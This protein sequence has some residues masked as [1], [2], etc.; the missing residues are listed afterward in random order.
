MGPA[1]FLRFGRERSGRPLL[2]TVRPLLVTVITIYQASIMCQAPCCAF[3]PLLCL[4]ITTLE[5][6]NYHIWWPKKWVLEE[7]IHLHLVS[8][9]EF[10]PWSVSEAHILNHWQ[11]SYV[12]TRWQWSA[13]SLC[14]HYFIDE[15]LKKVK[16]FTW[17]QN[18]NTLKYF[19]QVFQGHCYLLSKS[20]CLHRSLTICKL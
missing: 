8:R 12:P 15:A 11:Y 20:I 13:F 17:W 14:H 3:Y 1:I 5:A 18:S 10:E 6:T 4:I 19:G 9:T 7:V 16:E 2:V